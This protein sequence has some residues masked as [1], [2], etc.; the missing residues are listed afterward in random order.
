MTDENKSFAGLASLLKQ[1][2]QEEPEHELPKP[3]GPKPKQT[4]PTKVQ[5]EPLALMNYPLPE[6][7]E[8]H[9]RVGKH[10]KTG[11]VQWF[12]FYT[13][14]QERLKIVCD[15]YSGHELS[16]GGEVWEVCV[17]KQ[18]P[19]IVFAKAETSPA[20]TKRLAEEKAQVAAELEA[21]RLR[22][23]G[24]RVELSISIPDDPQQ[25]EY[26]EVWNRVDHYTGKL[27]R[28]ETVE[29]AI[30]VELEDVDH[31]RSQGDIEGGFEG[32]TKR[33]DTK[34][35]F[36]LQGPYVHDSL[37]RGVNPGRSDWDARSWRLWIDN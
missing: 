35:I 23:L 24:H 26:A 34:R 13:H 29:D 3:K 19:G 17:T 2:R 30:E 10:P 25:V 6:R 28:W 27:V 15:P 9:L 36:V 20:L 22:A 14:G 8:V 32:R 5:W 37:L 18:I 33:L 4:E 12:G 16:K 1:L 21:F 7:L 11:A 31:R